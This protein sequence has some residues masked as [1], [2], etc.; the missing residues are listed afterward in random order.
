M[1]NTTF[2]NICPATG[3][4][5]RQLGFGAWARHNHP[6]SHTPEALLFAP[7]KQEGSYLCFV[8]LLGS[9]NIWK[10]AFVEKVLFAQH[11]TT[12]CSCFVRLLRTSPPSAVGA[13]GSDRS[14][15]ERS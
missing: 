3:G 7:P 5:S 1:K 8:E 12:I 9:L 2:H 6:E 11:S 14:G 10:G 4:V 13:G 15:R